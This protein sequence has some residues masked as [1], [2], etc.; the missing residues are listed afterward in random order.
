[1]IEEKRLIELM[2]QARYE[3]SRSTCQKMHYGALMIND[4]GRV[5]SSGHNRSVVPELCYMRVGIKSG[6]QHERCGAVHAEQMALLNG[7][8]YLGPRYIVL[9]GERGDG[10]TWFCDVYYCT[11]CARLMYWAGVRGVYMQGPEGITYISI[12]QCL[13]QAYEW[14]LKKVLIEKDDLKGV[15]TQ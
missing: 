12:G 6:T 10:S 2:E 4:E 1:M 14:A 7:G 15:K 3:M 5:I 9:V 8:Y 13:R 11:T